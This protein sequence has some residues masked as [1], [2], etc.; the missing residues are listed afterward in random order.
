MKYVNRTIFIL[1]ALLV[2]VSLFLAWFIRIQSGLMIVAENHLAYSEYMKPLYFLIPLF[3]LLYSSFGLYT[4]IHEKSLFDQLINIIKANSVG[5]LVVLSY[6]YIYRIVDYSR[7]VLIIFYVISISLTFM[8]RIIIRRII[9]RKSNK[10]R[11][12]KKIII[13]GYSDLSVE[14]SKRLQ[15]NQHWGYVIQGVFDNNLKRDYIGLYK[16]SVKVLGGFKDIAAFVEANEIDEI[17]ITISLNEYALLEEIVNI[18]EK[19]GIYTRIIPDYYKVIPA[20]PYIEDLDG[21]PIISIR[22]IP[23]NDWFKKTLKRLIDI[24]ASLLGIVILSPMFLIIG[25]IIKIQSEGPIIFE[26]VRV[27][28]NRKEFKMYK[29]RSMI[30]QNES[31]EKKAWTTENDPRVTRCGAFFRKTSLDEFPQ[32]L[33]VLKGDMSLVG[34][35]PERPQFVEKYK[36]EIPKYMVKHQVR[37]G[38]TGWAQIHGLR[39]DTSIEQRIEYDLYYIENWSL[40]LEIRI[41][42]LT[43]F[44]GF[45]NKNAY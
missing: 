5:V 20:K 30:I 13:V 45:V 6:L 19:Q 35:R 26:Q 41:L 9:Y 23:L 39:G 38:M 31:A 8:E 25:I 44:R 18:C 43:F 24:V 37:P 17:I 34:P 7:M 3:L 33:N 22:K 1:D 11:N 36:E 32:L 28:L 27:G 16:Q 40:K 14:Y 10:L 29:F 21:L 4:S 15:M 2:A 42:I 12:Q